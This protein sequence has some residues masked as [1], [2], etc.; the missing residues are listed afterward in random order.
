MKYIKLFEHIMNTGNI[1][2]K[3]NYV[4]YKLANLII[5]QMEE[6]V[7]N[8]TTHHTLELASE[9]FGAPTIYSLLFGSEEKMLSVVNG[10]LDDLDNPVR[11]NMKTMEI[12]D[13]P[14]VWTPNSEDYFYPSTAYRML[15]YCDSDD[16]LKSLIINWEEVE[17]IM[18][19]H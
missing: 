14:K 15:K 8:E 3:K 16:K 13:D 5:D 2:A 7:K 4:L 11:F 6:Y 9:M 12:E 10:L 19:N 17:K 18:E 1:D